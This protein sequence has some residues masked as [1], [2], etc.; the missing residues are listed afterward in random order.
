MHK[1]SVKWDS[2]YANK[3]VVNGISFDEEVKETKQAK[4]SSF[5]PN[6]WFYYRF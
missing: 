2:I 6:R 1:F 4:Y 5:F 3:I